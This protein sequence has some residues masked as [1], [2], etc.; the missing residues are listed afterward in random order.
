MTTKKA[1]TKVHKK[2]P[3]NIFDRYL[4]ACISWWNRFV[5]WVGTLKIKR[6]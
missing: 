6:G 5:K 3:K 4:D 1:A 2:E